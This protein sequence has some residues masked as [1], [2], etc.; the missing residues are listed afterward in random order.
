M[1]KISLLF[2]FFIQFLLIGKSNST[3]VNTSDK[4]LLDKVIHEWSDAHNNFGFTKFNELYASDVMFYCKQLKKNE[5]VAIKQKLLNPNKVFIQSIIS[6]IIYVQYPNNVIFASFTKQ[7]E[8][9]IKKNW[10]PSYLLLFKQDGKYLIVG[11]S[12]KI[13][14]KNLKFKLDVNNLILPVSSI[15]PSN[16][17][18]TKEAESRFFYFP[19]AFLFLL[20]VMIYF[21]RRK[22]NESQSKIVVE[23]KLPIINKA[24]KE[25]EIIPPSLKE[26]ITKVPTKNINEDKGLL[27]EKYIVTKF[28]P[29]YF[30]LL[31]WTGDKY[32]YDKG[33]FAESNN[34]PDLLYEFK[35]KDFSRK[36]AVECKFRNNFTNGG[37]EFKETQLNHYKKYAL[38]NGIEV[39]MVFGIGG[40]PEDPEDLYLMPLSKIVSYKININTISEYSRAKGT[41]FFYDKTIPK[42]K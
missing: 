12:D 5:C 9:S 36:F 22:K 10:Y 17:K 1:K 38:E 39:Y 16:I 13:T 33:I 20:G 37:V 2:L 35:L 3:T 8:T 32:E 26:S 14:D 18:P 7:V 41:D 40:N 28:K 6:G 42:L 15:K 23:K 4:I 31:E 21:L 19:F 25:E 11:E 30:K 29:D 27:F 24:V 34:Y